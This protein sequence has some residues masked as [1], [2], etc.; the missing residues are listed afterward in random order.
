MKKYY[1]LLFSGLWNDKADCSGIIFAGGGVV[2][3]GGGSLIFFFL[4]TRF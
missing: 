3:N 2:F 1:D 4:T